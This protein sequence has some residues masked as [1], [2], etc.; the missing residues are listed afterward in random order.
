MSLRQC[1]DTVWE[2]IAFCI[3]GGQTG[4]LNFYSINYMISGFESVESS[5]INAFFHARH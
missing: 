1:P 5:G 3:K 4:F 2:N